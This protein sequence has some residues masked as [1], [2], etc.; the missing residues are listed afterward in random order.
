MCFLVESIRRICSKKHQCWWYY[1]LL[2]SNLCC[3]HLKGK[4]WISLL[5]ELFLGWWKH[6]VLCKMILR[7][8]RIKGWRRRKWKLRKTLKEENSW[9]FWTC[10]LK[11]CRWTKEEL[12]L[13]VYITYLMLS[14]SFLENSHIII[15][16]Q[17]LFI[18][19]YILFLHHFFMW[20][21]QY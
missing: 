20:G 21:N 2:C 14:D 16:N 9:L 3:D 13:H 11:K 1:H 10:L 4:S 6:N 17:I 12:I 5:L 8:M 18:N 15:S 19:L 7:L